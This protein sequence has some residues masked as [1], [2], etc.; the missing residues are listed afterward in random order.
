MKS[1]KN[2]KRTK[3]VKKKIYKKPDSKN[4][5]KEFSRQP[6]LHFHKTDKN[7]TV[8][9]FRCDFGYACGQKKATSY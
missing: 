1:K 3:I 7:Q 5:K 8:D 9:V 4:L 6:T 2:S